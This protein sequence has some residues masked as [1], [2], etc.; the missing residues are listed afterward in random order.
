[1][2]KW[3]INRGKVKNESF[4]TDLLICFQRK[5]TIYFEVKILKSLEGLMLLLLLLNSIATKL[6]VFQIWIPEIWDWGEKRQWEAS[7][8]AL[9]TDHQ[10]TTSESLWFISVVA[11]IKVVW[12][13]NHMECGR[14]RQCLTQQ[15]SILF[16]TIYARHVSLI[17]DQTY[18]SP[19][20]LECQNG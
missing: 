9:C 8:S 14:L 12:H 11:A 5:G 10:T 13:G 6:S 1:M 18:A 19:F 3:N 15:P 16:R 4:T 2:W 7:K 20:S 17:M